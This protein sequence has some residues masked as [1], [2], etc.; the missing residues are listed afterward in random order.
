MIFTQKFKYRITDSPYGHRSD[1]K[2]QHSSEDPVLQTIPATASHPEHLTVHPYRGLQT[3]DAQCEISQPS[4]FLCR[5]A[6]IPK[7]QST[8]AKNSPKISANFSL[9]K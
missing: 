2:T 5:C 1:P 6:H 3:G 8:A 4:P 9:I 7:K